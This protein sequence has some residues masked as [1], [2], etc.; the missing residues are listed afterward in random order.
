[1]I[2]SEPG[3]LPQLLLLDLCLLLL[4]LLAVSL[5]RNAALDDPGGGIGAPQLFPIPDALRQLVDII[6]LPAP[7]VGLGILDDAN[8]LLLQGLFEGFHTHGLLEEDPIDGGS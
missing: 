8:P 7:G 3:S 6:N 4:L 5:V 1:M 2:V